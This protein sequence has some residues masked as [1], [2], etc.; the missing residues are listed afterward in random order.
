MDRFTFPHD[1][2]IERQLQVL[3]HIILSG[4]DFKYIT[5]TSYLRIFV[6]VIPVCALLVSFKWKDSIG[7]AVSTFN[8]ANSPYFGKCIN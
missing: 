2:A 7:Y 6:P 5:Q 1:C 3:I 4:L 8:R